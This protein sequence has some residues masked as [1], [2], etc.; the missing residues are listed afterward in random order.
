MTDAPSVAPEPEVAEPPPAPEHDGRFS[1]NEDWAA[2]VFGLVLVIL[3]L[4]GV[5]EFGGGTLI[6]LGLFTS[7]AA[8]LASGEMAVAYFKV[9]IAS[10]FWPIANNGEKAVLFCFIFLFITAHGAGIWSVD[11]A[12]QV[13]QS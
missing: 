3:V 6:A 4:A 10:S 11:S 9:H 2:T 8:F 12:I 1:I 13:K 7:L 5:I